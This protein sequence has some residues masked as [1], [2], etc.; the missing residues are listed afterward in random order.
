[1]CGML[2]LVRIFPRQAIDSVPRLT[3]LSVVALGTRKWPAD[4]DRELDIFSR[5][6]N[7]FIGLFYSYSCSALPVRTSWL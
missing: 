2:R 6:A 4:I 1:M 3:S 5:S 7:G